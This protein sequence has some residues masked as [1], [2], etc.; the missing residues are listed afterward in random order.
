LVVAAVA[1]IPSYHPPHHTTPHHT[2]PTPPR[3]YCAAAGGC[4][5]FLLYKGGVVWYT[6]YCNT[7]GTKKKAKELFLGVPFPGTLV[8]VHS[9]QSSKKKLLS[10]SK[11][12]K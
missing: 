3:L 7:A 8:V 6:A 4:C 5:I 2:T 1:V 12:N 9:K 11:T 10:V